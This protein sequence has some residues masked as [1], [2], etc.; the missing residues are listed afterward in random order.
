MLCGMGEKL[1]AATL[2]LLASCF[3]TNPAN[4]AVAEFKVDPSTG[5][6]MLCGSGEAAGFQVTS[7]AGL[8]SDAE[9]PILGPPGNGV[10]QVNETL[11]LEVLASTPRL[12]AAGLFSVSFD[13]ADN[14]IALPGLINL[15]IT[16]NVDVLSSDLVA[17]VVFDDGT[18]VRADF[19]LTSDLDCVPE[20][21]A[22][23]LFI[24]GEVVAL[25]KR[26]R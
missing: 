13:F 8:L 3:L 12:F 23:G 6:A 15:A 17:F 10:L 9:L 7:R 20:P 11:L 24:G 25:M 16:P 19:A 1:L 18:N 5:D 14:P 4:A 2:I 21:S 26:R 22:A